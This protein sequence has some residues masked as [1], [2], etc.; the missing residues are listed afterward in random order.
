[1]LK[2]EHIRALRHNGFPPEMVLASFDA[3]TIQ[4]GVHYFETGRANIIRSSFPSLSLVELE[5]EVSGSRSYNTHILVDLNQYRINGQCSCPVGQ[6]CKHALAALLAYVGHK[7]T[8]EVRSTGSRP[9]EPSELDR[10][11]QVLE[12]AGHAEASPSFTADA[13]T[14]PE[15]LYL[16]RHPARAGNRLELEPRK[17][18][19][20]K[21][22]GYGQSYRAQ[23]DDLLHKWQTPSFQCQ[24]LDQDIAHLVIPHRH[25]NYHSPDNHFILEGSLGQLAL[26]MLFRTGRAYWKD[27][28][29][30]A[31]RAGPPRTLQFVWEAHQGSRQLRPQVTPAMHDYFQL[32]KLYYVDT[33]RGECGV[34]EHAPLGVDQV[35]HLL[36]APPVPEAQAKKTSRRLL[37]IIPPDVELPLP[38]PSMNPVTVEITDVDP[39]PVLELHSDGQHDNSP[40]HQGLSLSFDYQGHLLH[41]GHQQALVTVREDTTRYRIH[42]QLETEQAARERLQQS[43]GFSAQEQA[44]PLDLWLDAG[45]P[46]LAALLWNN[47]LDNGIPVLEQ[48]GWRISRDDSF[49]LAFT[50]VDNWEAELK[51]SGEQWFELGIGFE[52]EGQRINL[53]PILVDMLASMRSPQELTTLLQLQE[54]LL[55]PLEDG[56]WLKLESARLLRVLDT[57]IEL[58]DHAPLN[59]DGRLLMSRFQ[60][61]QL[62]ELL[63]D[64]A[65]NWKGAGEMRELSRRLHDFEGIQ[66]V[67]PPAGLNATLR[68]YQQQGLNWLQ[69]LSHY[70]FNG[71]LADDMGLGKTLQALAHLLLEKQQGH[72]QHPSLV[73]AP[74]SLMSN[75]RREVEKFTPDLSVLVLHGSQREADFGRIGE[76]DLILT[77]YP[78]ILRD[79]DFYREQLF[80]YLILDE[81]QSI[82]NARSKTTQVIFSLQARHRLCL[83][84]TPMENHLGELW[85]M[86]HFLMPGFLGSHERFARLFRIPVEKQGDKG[87]QVQLQKRLQPFMLRRTKQVVATELPPKTEIILTVALEGRQRDLYESVR[88]AMDSKVREEIRSRGLAHS[89]IVILDALLKLRQVCCDPRIM[90]LS[91]AEVLQESAKL[92]ML[93]EMLPELLEEGRKVLLFSQFTSMLALIEAAV[94]EHGIRYSL[95]TGKTRDRESAISAFQDGDAQV[96]L[97]SLK[98]GGTGLNL[99]AADTVIHYDPWWNPA[100]EQQ[101]TDRAYRIGQ[102]KPV[103]VY[104]L[105]VENTVEEK[106]LRLQEKKQQLV[107]GIYGNDP[108]GA[109]PFTQDE[110]MD[111][112]QPLGH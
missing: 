55:V 88:L 62:H 58:Y 4:R 67:T 14:R 74:T 61:S 64:P 34:L 1:M 93:M 15:L 10:W 47:F 86:F 44:H 51:S 83:T 19:R 54:Y 23:L 28:E 110:L 45:N 50:L 96:F 111:L 11:L 108:E 32:E 46:A 71:I 52:V 112:L 26:E 104:K 42:R 22:G 33:L 43:Y 30:P 72:P 84:G 91:G 17:A 9:E 85:S 25:S 20:L 87:R 12:Q 37:E 76:F 60:G 18:T 95:L 68:A 73:I 56:R 78:L 38:D 35:L 13:A 77:T 100:V 8:P 21:R 27:L 16:L 24:P 31:L 69:F 65:L 59:R 40:T 57:L 70:G 53:L 92:D 90:N 5:A 94:R 7:P 103:F 81:A 39:V 105:L 3:A 97:I 79:E 36:E 75:W 89:Q 82:K 29:T 99:T 49:Q 101:A 98:A 41:P 6:Q 66:P 106:I 2:P 107:D 63:N 109:Q 102:D 48:E 80:H